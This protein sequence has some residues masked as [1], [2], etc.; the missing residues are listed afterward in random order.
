MAAQRILLQLVIPVI[1]EDHQTLLILGPP[2]GFNDFD[3]H[4][5][6][7]LKRFECLRVVVNEHEEKTASMDFSFIQYLFFELN[8]TK[9]K[10]GGRE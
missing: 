4:L 5:D 3:N 9:D 7:R 1:Q 2:Q 6:K 10:I 8:V